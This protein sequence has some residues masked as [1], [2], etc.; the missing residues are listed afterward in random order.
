[1]QI[2]HLA[3]EL[4]WLGALNKLSD[5]SGEKSVG[6]C[7]LVSLLDRGLFATMGP[8]IGCMRLLLQEGLGSIRF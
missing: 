3:L 1:M 7:H 5:Y 8:P 4:I 6:L 2:R